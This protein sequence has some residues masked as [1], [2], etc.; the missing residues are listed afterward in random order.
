MEAV[1]EVAAT[2]ALVLDFARMSSTPP[3]TGGR[4]LHPRGI[5][6]ALTDAAGRMLVSVGCPHAR[7]QGIPPTPRGVVLAV[8]LPPDCSHPRTTGRL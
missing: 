8:P 6:R 7:S 2:V 4:R 1:E 5:G 3:E